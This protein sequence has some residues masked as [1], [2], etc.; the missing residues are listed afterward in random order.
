MFLKPEGKGS[1]GER[2]HRWENN[3]E[4]GLHEGLW[5]ELMNWSDLGQ[6]RVAVSFEGDDELSVCVKLGDFL[7]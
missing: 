6:G 4:T 5:T 1:F 7:D 3:I 2:R